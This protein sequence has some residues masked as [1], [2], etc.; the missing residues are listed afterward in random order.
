LANPT[1]QFSRDK[2]TF[3][4]AGQTVFPVRWLA[5]KTVFAKQLKMQTPMNGRNAIWTRISCHFGNVG[6]KF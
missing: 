4:K 3:D 1:T 5:M 2:N 6:R